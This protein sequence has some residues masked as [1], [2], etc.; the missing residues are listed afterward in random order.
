MGDR[1]PVTHLSS[2]LFVAISAEQY[3]LL[4]DRIQLFLLNASGAETRV[5]S[6]ESQVLYLTNGMKKMMKSLS[7]PGV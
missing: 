5:L 7:K 2:F 6:S 1:R 3:T 4:L